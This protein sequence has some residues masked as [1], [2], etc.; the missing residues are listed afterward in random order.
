MVSSSG[1][2]AGRVW[3]HHK[4]TGHPRRTSS[5]PLHQL[6]CISQRVGTLGVSHNEWSRARLR[7]VSPKMEPPGS[8]IVKHE[9]E[10]G[11]DNPI[12]LIQLEELIRR[13]PDGSYTSA[14]DWARHSGFRHQDF[15]MFAL[16]LCRS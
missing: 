10:D 4:Y 7:T 9:D 6:R 16:H 15:L 5:A 12:L 13:P 14:Q 8:R 1:P 11:P 2:S 3:V